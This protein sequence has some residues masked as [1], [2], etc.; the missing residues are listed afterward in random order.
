MTCFPPNTRENFLLDV[1]KN[2]DTEAAQEPNLASKF[3]RQILQNFRSEQGHA[4]NS[5]ENIPILAVT[6]I[7]RK[8]THDSLLSWRPT[9][10]NSDWL[11]I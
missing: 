2:R 3:S 9:R 4:N 7:S 10:N 5:T 8:Y 1:S 6:S 11:L